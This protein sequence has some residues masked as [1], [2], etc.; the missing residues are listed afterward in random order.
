MDTSSAVVTL[1]L[2]ELEIHQND[3]EKAA[4]LLRKAQRSVSFI[5][6]SPSYMLASKLYA[7]LAGSQ[8]FCLDEW[9]CANKNAY[10]RVV[11]CSLTR[12]C[13]EILVCRG[14]FWKPGG[15]TLSNML[16][17]TSM[18]CSACLCSG[19]S[20]FFRSLVHAT[21]MF[22]A[23][24]MMLGLVPIRAAPTSP[25]VALRCLQEGCDDHP[26][27]LYVVL[28]LGERE[29]ERERRKT[30]SHSPAI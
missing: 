21:H 5:T 10:D 3:F 24:R 20:P 30:C 27:C 15:N 16:N 14:D 29:R 4:A 7:Q 8:V 6:S 18:R 17:R 26:L 22:N 11:V 25:E 1:H 9:G 28:C 13:F 12:A 23:Q 19:A 2:A